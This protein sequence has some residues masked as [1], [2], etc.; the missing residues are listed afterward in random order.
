MKPSS[1]YRKS[2]RGAKKWLIWV[3]NDDDKSNGNIKLDEQ[4][5][6]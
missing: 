6:I 3:F 2:V 5:K 4:E 1:E